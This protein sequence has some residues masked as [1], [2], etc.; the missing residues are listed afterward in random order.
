MTLKNNLCYGRE[1]DSLIRIVLFLSS[2]ESVIHEISDGMC[3]CFYLR[4]AT[5]LLGG[6][7]AR[8]AD[9]VSDM[10]VKI[11]RGLS[12]CCYARPP[13]PPGIA[14]QSNCF[15]TRTCSKRLV[16]ENNLFFSRIVKCSFIFSRLRI[17]R[18][19]CRP[20]FL[21]IDKDKFRIID[22]P[23]FSIEKFQNLILQNRDRL[24]FEEIK[25]IVRRIAWKI[26]IFKVLQAFSRPML[27]RTTTLPSIPT[28]PQFRT[29]YS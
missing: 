23:C 22:P 21:F 11:K 27:R 14:K 3:S 13:E 25:N 15:S 1:S 8:L 24:S 17:N 4:L 5:Q 10:I 6:L 20:Y 29:R 28:L 18:I 12:R 9:E 2:L 19:T 16:L 26:F 7:G